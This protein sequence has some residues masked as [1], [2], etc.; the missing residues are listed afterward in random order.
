MKGWCNCFGQPPIFGG[1]KLK[2]KILF[3][4]CINIVCALIFRTKI[5]GLKCN[6]QKKQLQVNMLCWKTFALPIHKTQVFPHSPIPTPQSYHAWRS[7]TNK[8][9]FEAKQWKVIFWRI[10]K[11]RVYQWIM[12]GISVGWDPGYLVIITCLAHPTSK[13]MSPTTDREEDLTSPWHS[14]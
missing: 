10:W 5:E 8:R 1:L 6:Q 3:F 4:R 12:C 14:S 2:S 11:G 9:H 13:E 7:M